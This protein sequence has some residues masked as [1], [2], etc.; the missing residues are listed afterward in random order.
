MRNGVIYLQQDNV[1]LYLIS[2]DVESIQKFTDDDLN[3]H[4][5]PQPL[6]TSEISELYIFF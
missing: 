1:T 6:N 3:M 4:L 2:N 5:K